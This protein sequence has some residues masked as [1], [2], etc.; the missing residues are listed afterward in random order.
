M[1]GIVQICRNTDGSFIHMS[2]CPFV[3]DL[4]H[5]SPVFNALLKTK[6]L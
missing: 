4:A 2:G 1:R 6:V 3:I 5:T